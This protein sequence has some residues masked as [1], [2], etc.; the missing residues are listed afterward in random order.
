MTCRTSNFFEVLLFFQTTEKLESITWSKVYFQMEYSN[1]NISCITSVFHLWKIMFSFFS[2]ATVF[3]PSNYCP[4]FFLPEAHPF[5]HLIL[6]TASVSHSVLP[7]LFK[8]VSPVCSDSSTATWHPFCLAL[9]F[10][11]T[12]WKM[13]FKWGETYF[14]LVE[15]VSWN[16]IQMKFANSLTSCFT[17]LQAK[18]HNTA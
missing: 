12:L 14:F 13:F 15:D 10:C 8:V 17:E 5:C 2:K 1:P 6:L 4:S 16:G 3:L 7:V 18:I 9:F 11:L